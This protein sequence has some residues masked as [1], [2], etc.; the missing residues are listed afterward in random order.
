MLRPLRL[1]R[2]RI[3]SCHYWRL[4]R[5]YLGLTTWQESS[6]IFALRMHYLGIETIMRGLLGHNNATS[7]RTSF[8]AG[9]I[10]DVASNWKANERLLLVS[11]ILFNTLLLGCGCHG[12]GQRGSFRRC[13]GSCQP[14]PSCPSQLGERSSHPAA[15]RAG[16]EAATGSSGGHRSSCCQQQ[17]LDITW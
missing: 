7:M 12:S 17:Q 4:S 1:G 15:G 8:L 3:R 11:R 2:L 13:C 9:G 14:A 6:R 5:H 16:P 10:V